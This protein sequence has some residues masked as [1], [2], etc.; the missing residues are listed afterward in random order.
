[1]SHLDAGVLHE[2]L[3]GEIPSSELAPIQAHLQACAECRGRLEEQR[4]ILF[5]ADE[6]IDVLDVPAPAP[7]ASPRR[8]IRRGSTAW[9]QY[10]AWAA[11]VVIAAGLGYSARR[12]PSPIVMHDTVAV[13]SIG[14]APSPVNTV[15][16]APA[17]R[18]APPSG[19]R[20]QRSASKLNAP[21]ATRS[22]AMNDAAAGRQARRDAIVPAPGLAQG[23]V[24]G[25]PVPT[26]LDARA[27][28]ALLES[29]GNPATPQMQRASGD[30]AGGGRGGGRNL[31]ARDMLAAKS[32]APID[33]ITLHDAVLR[34][35]G[36]LRLI[37][38][39][40][41]LR[42]EAQG[43]F[44]RVVYP[45]GQGELVL[46]QQLIDGRVMYQL[47][48]PRLFPADSLALLRGKVRE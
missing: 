40:V 41:P 25:A 42:L 4:R 32:A 46:Q 47:I 38:G 12:Q 45:T 35:G 39:L 1:M 11:T 13:P 7:S 8:T 9:M 44:V 22:E 37:D 26:S 28:K 33:T 20:E 17:D 5:D 3:D 14:A 23:R 21:P 27:Q 6:L 29:M 10:A 18:A 48:A 19:A 43:S 36:S 2:L 24:A 34:L 15:A 30:V 31:D 16:P